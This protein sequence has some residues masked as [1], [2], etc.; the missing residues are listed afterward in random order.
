MT[1]LGADES[2]ALGQT[3]T[4]AQVL[5]WEPATLAT[6]ANT[7]S[8]QATQ[9]T[10]FDDG[11]YR[12][13]DAGRDFW[14]G[15]AAD[16]MRT[17]HDETRTKAKTFITSL[18]DGAAAA[19]AGAGT[20]DAAKTAVTN[21]VKSAEAK[22]YEVGADG[23][24]TISA[25]THQTL[26]S[27]LPDASS[28]T[29]A[30]GALQVDADASTTAVKQA[31]E[32]ARTAASSVHAAI[33]KAFANLPDGDSTTLLA[34]PKN[35]S[36]PDIQ[37]PGQTS[38][39]QKDIDAKYDY[40]KAMIERNGGTFDSGAD[41][42]NLLAIRKET[43]TAANG[44]NGV[45]DDKAVLLWVDEQG[46]KH[47]SEYKANTDPTNRYLNDENATEDVNGDGVKELGRL[48]AGSYEFEH[49]WDRDKHGSVGD[50]NIFGMPV[51]VE[52]EA[53]YDTNRDGLF[54]DNARGVGGQT[55]NWH[56]GR[57]GDV[58]SAGCQTMPPEDWSRFTADM[59]VSALGKF[60]GDDVSLR[61]TLV[62][63][64]RANG[65][66]EYRRDDGSV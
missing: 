16:A 59:G 56:C 35:I 12:A 9:L 47:V 11:M 36:D 46:I 22:G 8:T 2:A 10:A 23:T 6:R 45:Y 24:T 29:V 14:T 40:Y 64:D 63:E 13:V 60:T 32:N 53:E 19:E 25:S 20:L 54:N 17:A 51:G 30:A 33:E 52:A 5:A 4:V 34:S 39:A 55:M 31:L 48:P 42:K 3:L 49:R 62:N 44:G 1:T 18:Q 15:S 65:N 50:G 7:W 58:A 38:R 57:E 41:Q 27:Q 21:A 66:T 43:N 61:Y 26:L 28:Y 37:A